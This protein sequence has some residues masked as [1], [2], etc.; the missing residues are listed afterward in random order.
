M[1]KVMCIY[2]DDWKLVNFIKLCHSCQGI[3][4]VGLTLSPDRGVFAS[5][6]LCTNLSVTFGPQLI[7]GFYDLS[8]REMTK[9]GISH[10]VNGPRLHSKD[11]I[12]HEGLYD[13]RII[14]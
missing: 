10:I 11:D 9:D 13:K 1:L 8:A 5:G 6:L 3:L 14:G 2:S 12:G 4:D 7:L